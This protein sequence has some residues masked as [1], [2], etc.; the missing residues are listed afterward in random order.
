[1]EAIALAREYAES[2]MTVAE[3]CRKNFIAERKLFDQ[4][5]SNAITEG[6]VSDI[7]VNKL[8]KKAVSLHGQRAEEF[9]NMLCDKRAERKAEK[10]DFE[11][12]KR[13]MKKEAVTEE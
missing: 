11:R 12:R 7:T 3:F 9:F 1:M 5:L 2:P 8:R 6:W 13:K 10:L 4:T